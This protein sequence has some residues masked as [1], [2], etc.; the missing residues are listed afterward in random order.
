MQFNSHAVQVTM[1]TVQF[2]LHAPRFLLRAVQ[3]VLQAVQSVAPE[4]LCGVNGTSK[5]WRSVI[6]DPSRCCS[7]MLSAPMAD[8]GMADRVGRV[9]LAAGSDRI[10]GV[11]G[12]CGFLMPRSLSNPE[13]DPPTDATA[14]SCNHGRHHHRTRSN[15]Q[16]PLSPA[17]PSPSRSGKM[18]AE[19]GGITL[20]RQDG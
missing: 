2:A 4:S 17:T 1:R 16:R 10:A 9:P 7:R 14:T 11:S 5:R 6:L 8:P 19:Q 3:G 18:K 20:C 13:A 15:R 12:L